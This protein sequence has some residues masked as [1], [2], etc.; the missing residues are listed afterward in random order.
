MNIK[1]NPFYI[2]KCM[3]ESS[4]DTIHEQA[5]VRSFEIDENLCK[6]AENILLNP[7][8]RLEAEVCWFP[9]FDYNTI[10][11]RI[12]LISKNFREYISNLFLLKTKNYLA[13]ANILSLGFDSLKEITDWN[14]DEIRM[15][16]TFLCTFSENINIDKT[17]KTIIASRTKANFSTVLLE[18]DLIPLIEEQKNF[19]QRE[20]YDFFQK[21]ESEKSIEILTKMVE[22]ATDSGEK[23]SKW[24]LL[25]GIVSN[26][27]MDLSEFCNDQDELI[28]EDIELIKKSLNSTIKQKKFNEESYYKLEYDLKYWKKVLMPVILMK[29]SR[30]LNYEYAEDMFL[31]IRSLSILSAKQYKNY[32]FSNILIKLCDNI[33]AELRRVQDTLKS[34]KNELRFIEQQ[35]EYDKIENQNF[36][37]LHYEYGLV[38][39]TIVDMNEYSITI[40]EK[41]EYKYTDISKIKWS[42]T[43]LKKGLIT[44]TQWNIQFLTNNMLIPVTIRPNDDESYNAIIERLWRG[45]GQLIL[46]KFLNELYLGRTIKIG[47][48]VIYDY[49][50]ELKDPGI[51]ISETKLFCW[52]D[53]ESVNVEKGFLVVIGPGNYQLKVELGSDYNIVV[54]QVMLSLFFKH[55]K[56]K[57]IS[58]LKDKFK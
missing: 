35:E 10:S 42:N 50:M 39:K 52:K 5:E 33:F 17:I 16:A 30:G 55:G 31:L 37:H 45:V 51:F 36:M 9:G 12:K 25:E 28:K 41:N 7:K 4:K 27:E 24:F 14:N 47:E 11:E 57:N 54:V 49:G 20:L 15:A 8:K 22:E 56:G 18:E 46:D 21:V 2:L 26:Y 40:N 32:N 34:D 43:V 23:V 1:E 53:I 58:L 3:P 6:E 13:E 29:R 19:Y 44:E 38:F 48:I